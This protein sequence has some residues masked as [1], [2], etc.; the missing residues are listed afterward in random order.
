MINVNLVFKD[1]TVECANDGVAALFYS[2]LHIEKNALGLTASLDPAWPGKTTKPDL[3]FLVSRASLDIKIEDGETR[4]IFSLD[5]KEKLGSLWDRYAVEGISLL[6]RKSANEIHSALQNAFS[7]A[8]SRAFD[9]FSVAVGKDMG[10]IVKRELGLVI[11]NGPD[12]VAS[13]YF[14]AT[15]ARAALAHNESVMA[16]MNDA[17]EK[18]NLPHHAEDNDKAGDEPRPT[19]QA[20]DDTPIYFYESPYIM[21]C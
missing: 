3:H 7:T 20:A 10:E 5:L 14:Y 2:R 18:E 6:D 16:L 19:R 4:R 15:L 11:G 21:M 9:I 13:Y 8:G 1:I 17:P 12:D